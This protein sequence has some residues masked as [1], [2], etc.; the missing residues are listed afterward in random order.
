MN[1]KTR[2]NKNKMSK[3]D[4]IDVYKHFGK[5][6]FKEKNTESRVPVKE[7]PETPSLLPFVTFEDF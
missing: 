7:I 3:Q 1:P 4:M 6:L 2:D 5:S